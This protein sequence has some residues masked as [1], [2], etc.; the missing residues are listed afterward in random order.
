MIQPTADPRR[1]LDPAR[2]LSGLCL[3]LAMIA[4]PVQAQ[5]LQ[6]FLDAS[7]G[8][9]LPG[10]PLTQT[11]TVRNTGAS[12]LADVT[13]RIRQPEHTTSPQISPGGQCQPGG[14]ASTRFVTWAI[15]NLPAGQ[16][17]SVLLTVLMATGG[18]AASP[19]TTLDLTA[20]ATAIG[21]NTAEANNS[22]HAGGATR[23]LRLSLLA[24][25]DTAQAGD[26]VNY[27]L[28]WA[29]T[30]LTAADPQVTDLVLE[31]TVPPGTTLLSAEG[32]TVAGNTLFWDI[33]AAPTR[34]R[35]LHRFRVQVNSPTVVDRL[36]ATAEL[37]DENGRSAQVR[38]T[39]PIAPASPLQVSLGH[40][41]DAVLAEEPINQIVT[42]RNTSGATM[43]NVTV[44]VQQPGWTTSPNL[45]A[46]G[47]C[48]AGGCSATRLVG[49]NLGAVPAGQSRS[50]QLSTITTASTPTGAALELNVLARAD[51]VSSA[52]TRGV[53]TAGFSDAPLRLAV[54]TDQD[55]AVAGE[56][57]AYNLHYANSSLTAADPQVT[58]AWLEAAIPSGTTLVSADG[59]EQTAHGTVRWNLDGFGNH[60]SGLRR[61][62]VQVN[63]PLAG[64]RVISDAWL[65][66]NNRR[67]ATART[68]TPLAPPS[69]LR[70]LLD[71]SAG[72]FRPGEPMTQTVTVR[73][74]G[75]TTAESVSIQ[76]Q[77]PYL[78]GSH[79]L[80]V[81]AAC[82]GGGCSSR[83]FVTWNLGN[84]PAGQQRSVLMTTVA[85]TGSSAPPFGFGQELNAAASA[86]AI[87]QATAR[88]VVPT[89]FADPPLRLT[90]TA[91]RETALPGDTVAYTLHYA[92]TSLNAAD[93]QVT[94]LML[95]A[96][97]PAGTTALSS[98]GAVATGN[99]ALRWNLGATPTRTA[100]QRRFR[101]KVGAG[102][103][104]PLVTNAWLVDNNQRLANAR[105]STAIAA[106][107]SP[108]QIDLSATPSAQA[109]DRAL[110]QTV[111]VRNN[112]A[113]TLES[114]T[115]Q[116][117][118]PGW[119]QS[120]TANIDG[121]CPGGG[122]G[123]LRLI[124]WSFG[125]LPAG[126]SRTVQLSTLLPANAPAGIG[127]DL[128]AIANATAASSALVRVP[129]VTAFNDPR[130]QL[131][132]HVDRDRV[133]V[134]QTLD[135]AL[136]YV[137][138]RTTA[139]GPLVLEATIP[140]GASLIAGDGA[141]HTGDGTVRWTLPS[142]P[143]LT[144]S[145]RTFTVRVN[146][147]PDGGALVSRAWFADGQSQ[148]AGVRHSVAVGHEPPLRLSLAATPWPV[149]P[150]GSLLQTVVVENAGSSTLE[151]VA[152]QIQQPDWS[153]SV[154][155]NPTTGC[156]GGGCG[157]RRFVTW[158]L[159][160][161][162]AG[163]TRTIQM[164]VTVRTGGNAPPIGTI[165]DL[166]AFATSLAA[167]T[168]H[169]S[170]Y[171]VVGTT[172][173]NPGTKPPLIDRIFGN[174]F[175][176]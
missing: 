31:A 70:L 59:G 139:T 68:T 112:G 171:A 33:G 42:V 163:E 95:E 106:A 113:T 17:R 107:A 28:H 74:T 104:N 15:G 109:N 167:T 50:V 57:L 3:L 54:S 80:S 114:V 60:N 137:N 146:Q 64:H 162:A 13:V 2:L 99:G 96:N 154:Q 5:T 8:P 7:P 55:R 18:Q 51:D 131:A 174:G 14:C 161:L 35:G 94:D 152:V 91:D 170:G 76:V 61:L 16:S 121:T 160:N 58:Q 34:S 11:V 97:L 103:A 119:S 67:V 144:S 12:T 79:Q 110:D 63:T 75:A 166:D 1:H 164:S 115:L 88:S 41:A 89:G 83:R 155:L 52:A 140:D 26:T 24:D 136:T 21:A 150:G 98:D 127:L 101:V 47:A 145:T 165:L 86:I 56:R 32:A 157:P 71:H 168:R 78:S 65:H 105:A 134:G 158:Q 125:N 153:Q 128:H 156:P 69:P 77:Q 143:A 176:P 53:V 122:C 92:N 141:V 108:L 90:L 120:P 9:V 173:L 132:M 149:Q 36:T 147:V 84:I 151:Q 85:G 123:G 111:T 118:Q 19:G 66:D 62:V 29:N 148:P 43:N 102:A 49:W 138:A 135:Y 130:L 169:A 87:D 45:S 159:G 37:S 23:P 100:G 116:V 44:H 172:F 38:R 40:S 20:T 48:P 6:L 133:A 117:Q 30:S 81:G 175:E 22:V 124:N 72:P 126:Q 25:R 82:A 73:N 27:L 10:E 93:P 129:V 39:I 4:L 142:M 46:G